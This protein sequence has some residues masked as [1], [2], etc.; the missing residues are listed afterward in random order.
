MTNQ[1]AKQSSVSWASSKPFD[2]PAFIAGEWGEYLTSLETMTFAAGLSSAAAFSPQQ[3]RAAVRAYNGRLRFYD[4]R[5]YRDL[6]ERAGE[7][8]GF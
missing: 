5:Q 4:A 8:R 3:Q 1:K 6:L 7:M 2:V